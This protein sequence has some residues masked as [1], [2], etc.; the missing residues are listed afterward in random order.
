[1]SVINQAL[2][3][4][5]SK[6]SK[7]LG[8]IERVELPM[9]KTRPAW[10]WLVGGFALSL[11][12]GGWAVSQQASDVMPNV[13]IDSS[14]ASPQIANDFSSPTQ[15]VPSLAVAVYRLAPTQE[16]AD[17]PVTSPEMTLAAVTTATPKPEPLTATSA[18]ALPSKPEKNMLVEQVELTPQALSNQALTRANKALDSNDFNG[19]VKAYSEALRYTPRNEQV[20]QQLAALYYGKGD[21][22]KAFELLQRGVELDYDGETLRIALAKLLVK[23]GQNEAALS[24]LDHV[25]DG[26]SVEYL[27]LRA[28]LAQKNKLNDI[29]LDSYQRLTEK[30]ATNGRWWL[31]LAIQQERALRY[32]EA[33]ESY[34]MALKN[35]GLSTQSHAFIRQR[36]QLLMQ[37]EVSQG[38]N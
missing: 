7:T 29:A 9:A 6:Q 24:P 32:N 17:P 33:Q 31:G 34:Q 12:V 11:A 21:V 1:M 20:R 4:L 25:P 26:A 5:V 38:E 28:A 2:S 14:L 10:I 13:L 16:V 8:D 3:Q 37:Q 27:S 23:E 19:A 22:R 15:H 35:V 36:L 18:V 30:E